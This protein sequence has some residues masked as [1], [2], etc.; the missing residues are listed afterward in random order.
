MAVVVQKSRSVHT[1]SVNQFRS[2]GYPYCHFRFH[3]LLIFLE[4]APLF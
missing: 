2:E 3:S 1:G 4:I